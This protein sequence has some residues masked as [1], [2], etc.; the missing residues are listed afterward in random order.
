MPFGNDAIEV[1]Q[2]GYVTLPCWRNDIGVIPVAATFS[3]PLLGI[4]P[5]P[6]SIMRDGLVRAR[7]P[8]AKASD[9]YLGEYEVVWDLTVPIIG[10]DMN[11]DLAP[12]TET[13][14]VIST[15]RVLDTADMPPEDE[16]WKDARG[17]PTPAYLREKQM[18]GVPML[19]GDGRLFKDTAVQKALDAA[20]RRVEAECDIVLGERY[21]SSLPDAVA[22]DGLTV[23]PEAGYDYD[24][25]RISANYSFMRLRHRPV[26]RFDALEL[27]LG[28][29]SMVKIPSSYF[30]LHP[31]SGDVQLV[32]NAI[33]SLSING[34]SFP[35]LAGRPSGQAVPHLWH[36]SYLAGQEVTADIFEV[37]SWIATQ[38][39]LIT[40]SD[41]VIAGIA[42][43]SVSIDGISESIST[44]S[45]ATNSTY[46]AAILEYEK[47]I[48]E[49]FKNE[50][51]V[52]RGITIG[53]L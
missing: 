29:M 48:K 53:G 1:N 44:T 31:A 22:P 45:S 11:N 39:L 10:N 3:V 19:D 51:L 34:L 5:T 23:T 32:A 17:L 52:Y 12:M 40:I 35:L 24:P 14:D 50:A 2:G 16:S 13:F 21:F 43:Q 38:Q 36:A 46:G 42:S 26:K 9:A 25:Y 4:E 15:V 20:A 18:F 27:W 7:F 47:R 30:T 28:K 49:W 6:A 8:R 41:S 37:V 33:Q